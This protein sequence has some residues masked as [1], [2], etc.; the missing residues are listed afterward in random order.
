MFNVQMQFW[1]HW[2]DFT[3]LSLSKRGLV[4]CTHSFQCNTCVAKAGDRFCWLCGEECFGH[5]KNKVSGKLLC[6]LS[7]MDDMERGIVK[8]YLR[9]KFRRVFKKISVI[10]LFFFFFEIFFWILYLDRGRHVVPML[11]FWIIWMFACNSLW[12][13]V[14][15]HSFILVKHFML[16]ETI[17]I[18]IYSNVLSLVYLQKI[19]R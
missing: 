19:K 3:S 18:L 12:T 11:I 4:F 16:F 17:I 1:N 8:S 9:R 14:F 5:H 15:G 6:L 7:H 13:L 2:E 10:I